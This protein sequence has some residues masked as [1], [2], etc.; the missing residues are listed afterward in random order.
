[1]NIEIS[2]KKS[3]P[4]NM[5]NQRNKTPLN[6]RD[7]R[8]QKLS[9]QYNL[10]AKTVAYIRA[11]IGSKQYTRETLIEHIETE[12]RGRV[13]A[14][15]K[16]KVNEQLSFADKERLIHYTELNMQFRNGVVEVLLEL[17]E[18]DIIDICS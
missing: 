6:T 11:A 14:I 3:N 9:Q 1:M 17:N 16:H 13:E 7:P 4:Q 12:N 2:L 8:V 10:T 18:E 15:E 5:P